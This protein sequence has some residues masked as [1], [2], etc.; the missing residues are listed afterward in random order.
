MARKVSV[1]TLYKPVKPNVI[2]SLKTKDGRSLGQMIFKANE[3]ASEEALNTKN[4]A[5]YLRQYLGKFDKEGRNSKLFQV[6]MRYEDGYRSTRWSSYDN[7]FDEIDVERDSIRNRNIKDFEVF[8]MSNTTST[9]GGNTG[10]EGASRNDCL[11]ACLKKAGLKVKDKPSKFKK[12]IGVPFNEK[13]PIEKLNDLAKKLRVSFMVVRENDVWYSFQGGKTIVPLKLTNEHYDLYFHEKAREEV[14]RYLKYDAE[15]VKVVRRDEQIDPHDYPNT[16]IAYNYEGTEEDYRDMAAHLKKI[17]GG[18]MNLM[19]AYNYSLQALEI[20]RRLDRLYQ[21]PEDIELYENYPLFSAFHGGVHAGLRN[22]GKY[23]YDMN[24]MYPYFMSSAHFTF[25]V[26]KGALETLEKY[27]NAYGLYRVKFNFNDC[28]YVKPSE[29]ITHYDI[30]ILELFETPFELVNDGKPN[31]LLYPDRQNG[32]HAFGN[33]VKSIYEWRQ[34]C[35]EKYRPYVK[36]VMNSLWGSMC[37]KFVKKIRKALDDEEHAYF[38]DDYEIISKIRVFTD[39]MAAKIEHMDRSFKYPHARVGIFLTAYAR[40]Q[41]MKIIKPFLNVITYI[42]TDGFETTEDISHAL[43][44][45]KKI[46][47]FKMARLT[48]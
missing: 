1:S 31:A 41:M 7:I 22:T 5:D 28:P 32:H 20:H 16:I 48:G 34:T 3:R 40:W 38:I 45:S 17:S 4:L 46:G 23:D 2:N 44:L 39:E 14:R 37:E 8:T 21:I 19:R 11:W 47:E 15:N 43:P 35:D 13:V 9:T 42:N 10:N 25:P 26:K 33:F 36:K 30:K 12:W 18:V 29:W 24:S 27:A 6:T